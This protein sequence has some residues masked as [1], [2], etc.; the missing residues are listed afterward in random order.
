MKTAG[1]FVANKAT[2]LKVLLQELASRVE[3]DFSG[4]GVIVWD[5]TT[6][7]PILPMR[8]Q[9][10]DWSAYS[11]TSELLKELSREQSDFHDGFHVFGQSLELVQVSVYF[12]PPIVPELDLPLHARFFGGRYLAAAF[13]SCIPG[14]LCTG[15]LSAR[16]GP[17]V[18]VNGREI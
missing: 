9:L 10:A 16:Y 11:S 4:A 2:Q 6:P 14:V 17:Y 3:A 13:G 1:L 15:V 18:L 12:S 5:G 8:D 7:L